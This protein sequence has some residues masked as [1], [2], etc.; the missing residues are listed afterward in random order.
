M[1][2]MHVRQAMKVLD[3]GYDLVLE[4]PISDDVN[5]LRMLAKKAKETGRMVLVCHVL[6]YNVM[7]S[8]LK[9]LLDSGAIGR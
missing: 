1:D 2:R 9:S 6:R 4:K 7:I 8:K 5:E 3:L